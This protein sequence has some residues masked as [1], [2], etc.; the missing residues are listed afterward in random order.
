M[1]L[2]FKLKWT[3]EDT[4]TTDDRSNGLRFTFDVA[5]MELPSSCLGKNLLLPV[6]AVFL[7]QP[8]WLAAVDGENKLS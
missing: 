8:L 1:R 6:A 2:A 4:M 7:F 3:E 5:H